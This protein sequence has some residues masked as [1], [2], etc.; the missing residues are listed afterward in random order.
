[1]SQKLF[2]PICHNLLI[3]NYDLVIAEKVEFNLRKIKNSGRP[4]RKIRC[5]NC[6]RTLKYYIDD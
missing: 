3:K 5:H 1:M 4:I 6:K 2:C